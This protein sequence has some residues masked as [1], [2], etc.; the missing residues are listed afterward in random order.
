MTASLVLG[1]LTIVENTFPATHSASTLNPVDT[2]VT[3]FLSSSNDDF[4]IFNAAIDGMNISLQSAK[5]SAVENSFGSRFRVSTDQL[6]I[7]DVLS[8][9]PFVLQVPAR[10]QLGYFW[11][12]NE[13]CIAAVPSTG[14]PCSVSPI[15]LQ[16]DITLLI[17]APGTLELVLEENAPFNSAHDLTSINFQIV[18]EPGCSWLW[19]FLP[20]LPFLRHRRYRMGFE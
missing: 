15:G 3:G 18:P 17:D 1:Q 11:I 10:L 16:P 14:R 19:L 4:R 12:E 8:S 13:K 5:G 6:E 7:P 20:C 9:S 2:F